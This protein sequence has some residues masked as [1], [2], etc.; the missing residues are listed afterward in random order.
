MRLLISIGLFLL[1][2]ALMLVGVAERTV[3][4]PPANY[5]ASVQFE[6]ANPFIVIPNSV[7]KLHDGTPIV[8]A[9]GPRSVFIASGREADIAAWV[10]DTSHTQLSL[11]KKGDKLVSTSVLGPGPNYS[12]VDSD[13]WRSSQYR[14]KSANLKVSTEGSGAA[15]I[16][17]DGNTSAPGVVK[18]TWPVERNLLPSNI[19]I[20]TGLVLMLVAL[21]LNIMTI[22]SIRR[23]RGP[24]RKVP[25]APQGPRLRSVKQPKLAPPRGRR[26]AR[27]LALPAAIAVVALLSGCSQGGSTS[28]TPSPSASVLTDPPVVTKAQIL[29]IVKSV[30]AAADEGDAKNDRN[31]LLARVAGPALDQRSAYYSLR[32]ISPKIAALPKIAAN[33]VTFMLPAATSLWPRSIM[34]VTDE[35]GA[36]GPQMLVLQQ[37][38]PRSQYQLWYNIRLVQG[39]SIPSVPAF[40]IGAVPVDPAAKYLT[41]V[42][43][44]LPTKYGSVIDLGAGSEAASLF[45]LDNDEFFKQISQSQDS[46]VAA[47][48]NGK[49]TFSHTLGSPQVISL[50]SVSGGAIV[51]VSMIDGY[52]IKPTKAGSAITVTGLEKL[53]LGASGSATGIVSK[54]SDM[55]LFYVP[56][57]GSNG[58]VSLLGVTQSLLS[59]QSR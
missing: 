23:R 15:I 56:Q 50:A 6:A 51:A 29:R 35:P 30:A 1:S 49:I 18:V 39:A 41:V 28:A 46:E 34:V 10:G 9:T 21:I 7:L 44:E 19:L 25:R 45:S 4:A 11:N 20:I 22:N 38:S 42:P 5:T 24:R 59:V 12:P 52:T 14:A 27:K 2:L 33:K 26:A 55:L 3:W 16:A 54:Y 13:L 32:K 48:K 43:N 31:A 17:S 8:S 36:A 40:N 57:T 47:L 37:Q 53:M 58:A